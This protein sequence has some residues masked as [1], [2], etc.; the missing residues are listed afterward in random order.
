MN[1][2]T[3]RP[4][5]GMSSKELFAFYSQELERLHAII[6]DPSSAPELTKWAQARIEQIQAAFLGA[7][8]SDE[9]TD[10]GLT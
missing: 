9:S 3:V 5:S 10:P 1:S 4:K 7:A 8:A 6:K 2:T